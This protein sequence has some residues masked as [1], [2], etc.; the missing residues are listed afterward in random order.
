MTNKNVPHGF[1]KVNKKRISLNLYYYTNKN[2]S[3]TNQKHK[4][5][6]KNA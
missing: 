4:T 3:L 1:T 6:W 5:H 2:L